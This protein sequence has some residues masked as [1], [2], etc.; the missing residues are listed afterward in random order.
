MINIR[1]VH[2]LFRFRISL[3]G[4]T[5]GFGRPG[6]STGNKRAK[7]NR[8]SSARGPYRGNFWYNVNFQYQVGPDHYLYRAS[9]WLSMGLRPLWGV[10]DRMWRKKIRGW[11]WFPIS[12]FQS[13]SLQPFIN[14]DIV[15]KSVRCGQWNSAARGR[16]QLGVTSFIDTRQANLCALIALKSLSVHKHWWD[17]GPFRIV[18]YGKQTPAAL[19]LGGV[20]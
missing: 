4:W 12:V 16:L 7:F 2:E 5:N 15:R 20:S 17:I 10:A 13:L 9:E 3:L 8:V 11:P 19:H 6:P 1:T 14:V 18:S